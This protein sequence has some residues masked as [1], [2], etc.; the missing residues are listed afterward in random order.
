MERAAV[1]LQLYADRGSSN[2]REVV[3][4][5]GGGRSGPDRTDRT[6]E[7]DAAGGFRG[8]LAVGGFV[9]GKLW[10]S[11][12]VWK[13]FADAAVFGLF[14]CETVIIFL[15]VALFSWLK[16][17]TLYANTRSETGIVKRVDAVKNNGKLLHPYCQRRFLIQASKFVKK[18][19]TIC[20]CLS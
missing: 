17:V 5:D 12:Y 11:D 3:G 1:G 20:Q 9:Q 7:I 16:Y 4:G 8:E 18:N 6:V 15:H 13:E 10:V 2:G 14:N 19:T